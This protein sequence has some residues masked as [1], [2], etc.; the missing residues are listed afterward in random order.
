MNVPLL[1]IVADTNSLSIIGLNSSKQL[2]LI[3][4]ILPISNSQKVNFLNEYKDCFDE[5]STLPKVHHITIDQNITPAVTPAR[6]IPIA[7]LDKL[8][9]E[10]ERMR[11]L[12]I[13]EPV[14]EPTKWVNHLIKVEKSNGKLQI[15][16]DPKHYKLPT[17]EE[18]FS[19]ASSGYWQIKVDEES[20]KLLTFSTP[21]G[22]LQFKCLPYGI[23]SASE[24][25]QKDIK[26]IIE[27][28]RGQG[29]AKTISSYE[30][31]P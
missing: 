6:K 27:G 22:R 15:C 9:L 26:G 11:R 10:L 20:S 13:I 21:F 16:L 3:K 12:D 17:A 30:D 8:K 18:V 4:R 28:V 14:N 5:I 2:N 29:I 7:F 23:H 25:F 31:R 1:F 19:D 24:V